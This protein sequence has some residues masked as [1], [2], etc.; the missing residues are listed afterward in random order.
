M[1]ILFIQDLYEYYNPVIQDNRKY[2]QLFRQNCT[3]TQD[4]THG[5]FRSFIRM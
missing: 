3:G 2:Y 4:S 5:D 1:P